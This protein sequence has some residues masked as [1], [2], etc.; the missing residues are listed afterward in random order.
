MMLT[1]RGLIWFLVGAILSLALCAPSFAA[2]VCVEW[3]SEGVYHATSESAPDGC[4]DSVLLLPEELAALESSGGGESSL[5]PEDGSQIAG[6]ILLLWALAWAI[7]QVA[8]SLS[9]DSE[10]SEL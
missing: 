1:W 6:S 4:S 5:S 10:R 9:I 3:V 2:P 8:R 7:R